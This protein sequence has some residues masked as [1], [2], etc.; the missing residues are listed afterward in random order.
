MTSVL[1]NVCSHMKQKSLDFATDLSHSDWL[2]NQ[3][4]HKGG[5][6]ALRGISQ[7]KQ[8]KYLS[9]EK[10]AQLTHLEGAN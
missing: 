6:F 3:A 4:R 1:R 5:R 8:F 2:L 10:L 7:M 9:A